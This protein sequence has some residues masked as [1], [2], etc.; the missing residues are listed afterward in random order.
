MKE[1][2]VDIVDDNDEV[3]YASPLSRVVED[4]LLKQIRMVKC[5]I[6]NYDQEIL[7]CRNALTK[8]KDEG[9]FDCPLT[10][11][12]HAGES[13]EEALLRAAQEVFGLDISELPFHDLGTLSRED[14]LDNFTQVYEL[15]YN[16]LP[17]FSATKFNDFMWETP[18]NIITQFAKDPEGEKSLS[19]CLKSFYFDC[20]DK[21][22][23]NY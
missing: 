1:I 12:V 22:S 16:E 13:Y 9:L 6:K 20:H 8:K 7:L 3:I 23:C 2:F 19:T 11:I 15:T 4:G 17:D 10:A 14:G 18:L 21:D 5:F